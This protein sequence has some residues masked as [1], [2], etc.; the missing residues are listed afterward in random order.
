MG[1]LGRLK[2][3]LKI[4]KEDDMYGEVY[5]RLMKDEE[6]MTKVYTDERDE[7][8]RYLKEGKIDE[9]GKSLNKMKKL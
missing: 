6:K 1:S 2:K 5:S 9:A 3:I 4:S 8:E 7:C